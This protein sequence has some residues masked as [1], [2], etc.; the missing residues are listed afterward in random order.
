MKYLITAC[1]HTI[2]IYALAGDG[3]EVVLEFTL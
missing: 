1:R 2:R 3:T